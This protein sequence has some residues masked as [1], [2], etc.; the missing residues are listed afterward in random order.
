[1][2]ISGARFTACR[3]IVFVVA[4]V[5][6]YEQTFANSARIVVGN[7]P[8]E[9]RC[10]SL[11]ADYRGF[12]SIDKAEW[13]NWLDGVRFVNGAEFLELPGE[14]DGER[15]LRQQFVPTSKGTARVITGADV[16]EATTYRLVQSVKFEEGF[17]WGGDHEGG[18]L[19]FGLSGG[20]SPS[21]KTVDTAGFSARFMWRGNRDGTAYIVVYSYAA[22]RPGASGEDFPL[23]GF[24]API[25]EWFDLTMEIQMNSSTGASD[26][27][28]R[29]WANGELLLDEGGVAWQTSGGTPVIDNLY[30]S[31]FY[32]G[33]TSE[34]SPGRTTYAQFK[35]V[36]WSAVVNGESGIDPDSGRTQAP[37]ARELE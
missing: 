26:G 13:S 25:G 22:D 37:P 2:P 16:P 30:F 4:S 34:W 6:P 29:A 33:A 8:G 7:G 15:T 20:T 23:A 17:D 24:L 27:R 9:A 14:V 21:G 1:M 28:M 5:L 10:L 18:K 36:C 11:P 12:G 3:V 19:G 35:D 32:G 31:S